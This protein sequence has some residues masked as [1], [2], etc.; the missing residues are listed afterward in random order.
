MCP[1]KIGLKKQT[2]KVIFPITLLKN[3]LAILDIPKSVPTEKSKF[4]KWIDSKIFFVEKTVPR[5][6][7][8]LRSYQDNIL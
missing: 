7:V 2:K 5:K 4:I 1:K 8:L 3:I 6:L